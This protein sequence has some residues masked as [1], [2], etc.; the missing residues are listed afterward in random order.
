MDRELLYN[1]EGY[2]DLTAYLALKNISKGDKAMYDNMEINPGEVWE[3]EDNKGNRRQLVILATYGGYAASIQLMDTEPRENGIQVTAR[4]LMYADTGKVGYVFYD[5]LIDFV[6]SI[7]E[8]E[9]TEIKQA[10]GVTLKLGEIKSQAAAVTQEEYEHQAKQLEY[11]RRQYE[12]LEKE[13]EHLE[14]QVHILETDKDLLQDKVNTLEKNSTDVAA[15]ALR[16]D[17][18]PAENVEAKLAAAITEAQIY[19]EQYERLLTS[20]LEGR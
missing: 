6:K 15:V 19:K 11:W 3:T 7:T 20:L 5:R 12:D 16:R 8:E 9:F 2:K 18:Q 4:S 14:E 1:K 17:L 13:A 10:I